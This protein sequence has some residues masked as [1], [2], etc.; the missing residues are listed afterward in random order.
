MPGMRRRGG[1]TEGVAM[2]KR[3]AGFG[4]PPEYGPPSGLGDYLQGMPG[5]KEAR[6]AVARG[7]VTEGEVG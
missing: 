6:A 7:S 5:L 1:E 2:T 3:C 4:P